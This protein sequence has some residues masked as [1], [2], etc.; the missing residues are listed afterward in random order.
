MPSLAAT[1]RHMFP[2]AGPLMRAPY[3]PGGALAFYVGARDDPFPD[4]RELACHVE[5]A[6]GNGSR[7]A[8]GRPRRS[9]RR[10][11]ERLIDINDRGDTARAWELLAAL[12][13]GTEADPALLADITLRRLFGHGA[14]ELTFDARTQAFRSAESL[15]APLPAI[16]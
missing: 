8:G 2:E 16:A 15:P 11:A 6:L 12:L 10:R 3:C 5:E 4:E 1:L 14:V 9:I 13:R 7:S